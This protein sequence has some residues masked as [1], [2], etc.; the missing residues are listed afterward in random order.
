[1]V[2][3]LR[4][5]YA[6]CGTDTL[7][8]ATRC[9][10]LMQRVV[11]CEVRTDIAYGATSV[12]ILLDNF[13]TGHLPICLRACY[14]EPGT[15]MSYG[16]YLPT[17]LL[18]GVRTEIPSRVICLRACYAVSGTEMAYGAL[19]TATEEQAEATKAL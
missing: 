6:L 4:A 17:R 15:D 9:A 19:A 3:C 12:A 16:G 7:Y 5:C 13:V 14:A 2:I 10:E 18:H 1:M 11:L 8:D